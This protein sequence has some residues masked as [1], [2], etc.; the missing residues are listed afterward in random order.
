MTDLMTDLPVGQN[1][2]RESTKH[3]ATCDGSELNL[4]VVQI[5][6]DRK[7]RKHVIDYWLGIGPKLAQVETSK[8][9]RPVHAAFES[10]A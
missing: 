10:P 1:Q 3:H 5:D 4:L 6:T 9:P 2:V 7:Q 8:W